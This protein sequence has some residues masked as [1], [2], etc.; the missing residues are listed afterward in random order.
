MTSPE[1]RHHRPRTIWDEGR[2]PGREVAALL[3]AVLLTVVVAELL[4]AGRLGLLFDLAFVTLCLFA[5]LAVRPGDFFGVGVLPPLAMLAVVTLLAVADPAAVAH[6]EDGVVQAT[7]SGL[8][9]HAV[10]LA[11]GYGLCLA[12]LGVRRQVAAPRAD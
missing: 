11:V 4:L 2:T 9:A 12:V 10:A 5:A 3:V 8:S 7:V 1:A 6:A